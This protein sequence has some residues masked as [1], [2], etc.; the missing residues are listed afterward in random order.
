MPHAGPHTLRH[1]AASVMLTR[2][3]PLKVVCEI[4]GH[5]STAVTGDIYDHV[6]PDV[7]ARPCRPSVTPSTG[8]RRATTPGPTGVTS[9]PEWAALRQHAG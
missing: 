3:V 6:S 1:S 2:G 9:V 7:A 4:L 8:S 5:A